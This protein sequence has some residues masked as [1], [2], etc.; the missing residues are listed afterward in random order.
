MNQG[1]KMKLKSYALG[2]WHEGSGSG[3]DLFHAVSGERIVEITS[4]GL[5]YK[6]ML[7]YDRKSGGPAL[8]KMTFHERALML[9][10]LAQYLMSKKDVFY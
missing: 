8:R 4:N 3:Q 7:D 10:A 9:K 1:E 6:A 5:D 2:E